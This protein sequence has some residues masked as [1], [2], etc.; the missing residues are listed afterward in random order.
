MLSLHESTLWVADEVDAIPIIIPEKHTDISSLDNVI[1][2]LQK[3][4][5]ASDRQSLKNQY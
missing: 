2:Q 4:N 3:K 1:A 5:K